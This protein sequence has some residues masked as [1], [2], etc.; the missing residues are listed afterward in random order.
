[1]RGARVAQS[2]NL[3]STSSSSSPMFTAEGTE[4]SAAI[5]AEPQRSFMHIVS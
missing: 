2:L 4:A 3:T 1:M 5:S